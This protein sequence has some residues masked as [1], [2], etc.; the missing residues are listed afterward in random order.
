[1]GTAQPR[2]PGPRAVFP[3]LAALTLG[4]LLGLGAAQFLGPG[5]SEREQPEVLAQGSAATAAPAAPLLA[6]SAVV[7]GA[8]QLPPEAA[9]ARAPVAEAEGGATTDDGLVRLVRTLVAMPAFVTHYGADAEALLELAFDLELRLRGATRAVALLDAPETP[10]PLLRRGAAALEAELGIAHAAPLLRRLVDRQVDVWLGR[11]AASLELDDGAMEADA[12]EAPF[13]FR[14]GAAE[15]AILNMESWGSDWSRYALADPAGAL[16]LARELFGRAGPR[17]RQDFGALFAQQLQTMGLEAEA[18]TVLQ[19]LLAEQPDRG[20]LLAQLAQLDPNAAESRIRSRLAESEP[21]EAE[22]LRSMLAGLLARQ[23]RTSEALAL[24]RAGLPEGLNGEALEWALAEHAELAQALTVEEMRDWLGAP[25]SSPALVHHILE[26][27][28]EEGNFDAAVGAWAAVVDRIT[29][30]QDPGWLPSLPERL[31]QERG[32]ELRALAQRLEA[33]PTEN[34][35]VLGDLGDL[36]VLLGDHEAAL[37]TYTRAANLDP[38]DSEWTNA[39]RNTR[40]RL[41]GQ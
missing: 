26:R 6:P 35:E 16:A 40:A 37:R 8:A 4:L 15:Q 9:S 30:G 18:A 20:D 11:G 33:L 25:P 38:T 29:A 7:S 24:V 22:P 5:R 21:G 12:A 32:P 1:M 23:G 41:R 28:V 36:W 27:H 17:M 10:S 39:L 31:A 2:L 34:D 14:V 13:E 3:L 19:T